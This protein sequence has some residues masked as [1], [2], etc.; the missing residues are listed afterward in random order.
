MP[1]IEK[2]VAGAPGGGKKETQGQRK[3]SGHRLLFLQ[4]FWLYFTLRIN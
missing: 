4:L 1:K 3:L 2:L